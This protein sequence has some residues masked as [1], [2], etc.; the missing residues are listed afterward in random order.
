MRRDPLPTEF[1][2]AD[3]MSIGTMGIGKRITKDVVLSVKSA[4]VRSIDTAP[5]Y[6]Y[7]NEDRVGYALAEIESDLFCIT[8][9]ATKPEDVR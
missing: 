9:A 7:K 5:T 2:L 3:G 1:S 6:R 4:G 8:K